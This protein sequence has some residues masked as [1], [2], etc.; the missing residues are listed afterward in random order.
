MKLG[1]DG[2][3]CRAGQNSRTFYLPA[4]LSTFGAHKMAAARALMLKLTGSGNPDSL[5][6]TF[7]GFLFR[8]LPNT[9]KLKM[10]T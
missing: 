8:H 7:M 3:S 5:G 9:S 10:K 6:Q 1:L 2:F 4:A